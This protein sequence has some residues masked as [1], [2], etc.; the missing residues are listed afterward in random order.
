MELLYTGTSPTRAYLDDAGLDLYVYGDYII[1][2]GEYRDIDLNVKIKAPPGYWVLLTGR[3]SSMRNRRLLV[4]QGVI[5][6]GYIGPLYAG[7]T[8]MST[9]P[10]EIRHGERIAQLI[11]FR[12]ETENLRLVEVERLP[13][14]ERGDRGFGSSGN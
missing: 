1:A 14:T 13:E 8:N 9:E 10:V 5:D 12:N 7:V 3:S 6:P 11:A 2:P 4:S